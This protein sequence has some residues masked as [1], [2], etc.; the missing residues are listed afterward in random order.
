MKRLFCLF[1]LN[2]ICFHM[3][4]QLKVVDGNLVMEGSIAGQGELPFWLRSDKFGSFPLPGVSASFV[5]GVYKP[6]DTSKKSEFDWSVGLEGRINVGQELLTTLTDGY[7][8]VR[9]SIFELMGGRGKQI[10]GLVDTSLSSGAFAISGNALGIPQLQLSIPSF[11]NIPILGRLFSI[12]GNFAHGWVGNTPVET[13]GS[14]VIE[15]N[16]YFFQQ[17]IY[18]RFGKPNWRFK[19]SG[20]INHQGFWGNEQSIYGDGFKLS[21]FK[22]YEYVLLAKTYNGS[23]IGKQL[24]S[25]DILLEYNFNDI[26]VSLYRQ[27][28]IYI[29]AFF[30]A[31]N[32]RDG[33]N[34]LSFV[35]RKENRRG[36]SWRRILFEVFYSL[37]QA[38]YPWSKTTPSGAENYYNSVGEYVDGWSYKGLGLGNPFITPK[39][40]T[41]TGLPNY[42]PDYFNN[43]RVAAFHFGAEG[44]WGN[45][46]F[47]TRLSY[48]LNYG[49]FATS[50]WGFTGAGGIHN[51]P[52]WGQFGELRQ[53]SGYLE[54]GR[55][56][57]HGVSVGF[58]GGLDKGELFYNC[59]AFVVKV[60]KSF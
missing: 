59:S 27:F 48:S 18:G 28:F 26:R 16:T 10:M 15:V 8:K 5:G 19:L 37:D 55:K 4:G 46:E 40:T 43:N 36:L 49:T 21:S 32:L 39:S 11:Y 12:K 14:K 53:F 45:Y 60:S 56:F 7:A 52:L 22:T 44:S 30:H 54:I 35:N 13:F 9:L 3:V 25:A 24:G 42:P 17:S 29:G 38:G 33:L 34:G 51:P 47:S 50:P 41:R 2:L 1:W 6:F 23:K 20:G 57:N 58:I 31:A